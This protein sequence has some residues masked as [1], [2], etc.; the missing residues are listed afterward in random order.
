M[1]TSVPLIGIISPV[2]RR[3]ILI[4]LSQLSKGPT[5]RLRVFVREVGDW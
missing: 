1:E 4:L 2:A 5:F 3:V